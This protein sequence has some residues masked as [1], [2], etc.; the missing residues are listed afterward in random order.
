MTR[1]KVG[2]LSVDLGMLLF[3]NIYLNC[4]RGHVG[5]PIY[6]P[7]D[8]APTKKRKDNTTIKSP[9]HF[10]FPICHLGVTWPPTIGPNSEIAATQK[11]T[12]RR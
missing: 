4:T 11:K 10:R 1:R 2:Q 12:N 7:N 3:S 8:S 9:H 5:D 6:C